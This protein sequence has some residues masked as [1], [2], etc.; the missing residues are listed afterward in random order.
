MEKE[1][2]PEINESSKSSYRRTPQRWT[3]PKAPAGISDSPAVS[4]VVSGSLESSE[5][6]PC[7]SNDMRLVALVSLRVHLMHSDFLTTWN[8]RGLVK[9][10]NS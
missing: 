4:P 8:E 6:S 10:I 1:R 3:S 9:N 7:G 2:R 5:V